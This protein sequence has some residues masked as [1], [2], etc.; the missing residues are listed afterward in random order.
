[1]KYFEELTQLG[2]T[3]QEAGL[4]LDLLE[5]GRSSVAQIAKRTRITTSN[6]YHLLNALVHARVI[7]ELPQTR[8]KQ[9]IARDPEALL[10]R[11]THQKEVAERIIPDLR[12]LY[13]IEKNKPTIRFFEGL[14]GIQEIYLEL[15]QAKFIVS[16]TSIAKLSE[17]DE[18]F[19]R[20]LNK[21]AKEN[22]VTIHDILTTDSRAVAAWTKEYLKGYYDNKFLSE[23]DAGRSLS[24]DILIWD[25]HV[26]LITLEEPIFGTIITQP[27]IAATMRIVFE[28]LWKR[29]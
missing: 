22:Q 6:C 13:T 27:Y 5:N 12:A 20:A 2:F 28:S 7:E 14:E 11:I 26:A 17:R 16:I 21:K 18:P 9:Y 23:S 8:T 10:R 15:V 19:F 4:Y 29:L 1:M 3:K 24:T 25:D